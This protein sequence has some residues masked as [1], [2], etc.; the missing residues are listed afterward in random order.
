MEVWK[1]IPNYEVLY[2]VSNKGRVRSKK[3]KVTYTEMH[4]KRLWKSRVLKE[5]NPNGR[6]VRVSLWKDGNERS[7][8]VHRLVAKAF[9]PNPENKPCINHID[10]NPRNNHVKN[11]EWATYEENQNHAFD[12]GLVGT[13]I[14]IALINKDSGKR[15]T[16]RSMSKASSYIGKNTGYISS[17][18]NRGKT[19]IEGYEIERVD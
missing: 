19:E 2:E 3:G 11:L 10:G 12:N 17:V 8:L 5:K 18:L 9:I 6:D 4:G 7:F 16:F 15:K 14:R 13:N 1:Q